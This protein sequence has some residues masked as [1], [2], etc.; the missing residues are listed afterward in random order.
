MERSS[1]WAVQT[2]QAFRISVLYKAH[3]K[4]EHDHFLEQM[5][6]VLV[7]RMG[8]Q[9]VIIEGDYDNIKFTTQEDLF[10]RSN[11]TKAPR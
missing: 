9:V 6:Q 3:Q 4:A 5:M 10:C 11:F 8:E 1:L 2:P 7:E